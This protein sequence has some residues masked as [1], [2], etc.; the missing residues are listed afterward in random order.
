MLAK[1]VLKINQF[2][3]PHKKYAKADSFPLFWPLLESSYTR[4]EHNLHAYS[5]CIK[6]VNN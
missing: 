6:G 1:N 3:H 2:S 5:G 4:F